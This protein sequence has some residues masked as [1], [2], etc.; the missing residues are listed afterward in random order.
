MEKRRGM[1]ECLM[2]KKW[3]EGDFALVFDGEADKNRMMN[4]Q[5]ARVY[6]T[7]N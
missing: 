5:M 1:E 6:A 2:V 7:R 4:F 3:L